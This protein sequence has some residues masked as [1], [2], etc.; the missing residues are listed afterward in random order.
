MSE[1]GIAEYF[2]IGE[3]VGIMAT[4]FITLYYSRR[5]IRNLRVDLETKVL[6]DLDD[7]L[8]GIIE[9]I[10]HKPAL[11]RVVEKEGKAIQSEEVV[12]SYA[13]LYMCSHAFHMRQ[14]K[15]LSDNEWNGWLRWMRTA[16]AQGTISEYWNSDIDPR[17]W[18]D[19]DFEDFINNE[20][21]GKKNN[22]K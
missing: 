13:I 14:R 11:A 20:I 19:P 18:F 6:N 22:A 21:I 2:G 17:N 10:V 12:F 5:E 15:V 4:F 3:A 16:F 1:L 7:K 8:H 9:T